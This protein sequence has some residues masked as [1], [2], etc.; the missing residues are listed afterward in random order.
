M[1]RP[2][3]CPE[4]LVAVFA[5]GAAL[6]GLGAWLIWPR[7]R[8]LQAPAPVVTPDWLYELRREAQRQAITNPMDGYKPQMPGGLK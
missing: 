3:S 5:F 1:P 2:S 8:E 7:P 4:I 6:I